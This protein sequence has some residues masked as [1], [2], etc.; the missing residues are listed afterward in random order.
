MNTVTSQDGTIIAFEQSG[1]GPAL[2]LVAGAI[3][4]R[5][6]DQGLAELT[7]LLSAHLTVISYDRR[8]RG[9][10]TDTYPYALQR[11]IED[12]EAL[13]DQAGGSA[14][15]YGISSGGVL[16]LEATIALGK[17]IKKLAIYEAP[18]NDDRSA[19]QAWQAYTQQLKTLLAANRRGDAVALFMRLVGATDDQIAEVRS[20][21]VWPLFEA[22]APTLA[23]DHIAILGEDAEIPL[24]QAARVAV[25]ALIMDGAASF[26]FMHVTAL[27]LAKAMPHG[28]HRTL[29]GQT[30]E[31]TAAAIAPVLIEFFR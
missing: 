29:A 6:F 15:V 23:Y 14:F 17:K 3:Q 22:V 19:Q 16:A 25:P 2:I 1:T 26:P 28:Q 27:A 20:T 21:P 7:S 30:H 31:V 8:G 10:S 9:E 13:I 11:E 12:I 18:C 24:T 5:A 4:Y